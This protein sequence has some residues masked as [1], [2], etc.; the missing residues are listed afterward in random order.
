MT[1]SELIE[2]LREKEDIY[3]EH[4][5]RTVPRIVIEPKC[6]VR[7]ITEFPELVIV[8][9]TD[10]DDCTLYDCEWHQQK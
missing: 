8:T 7:F 10:C 9:R 4:V 5:V 1:L 6:C 3:G 2:K